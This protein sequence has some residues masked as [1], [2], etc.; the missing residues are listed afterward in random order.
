MEFDAELKAF[1]SNEQAGY[2]NPA[3][4]TL[5]PEFPSRLNQLYVESV[6]SYKNSLNKIKTTN[7]IPSFNYF[8]K[9]YDQN[10]DKNANDLKGNGIKNVTKNVII[11]LKAK[12][13]SN[14]S[15]NQANAN[16]I[17]IHPVSS[18]Y[19]YTRD[20]FNSEPNLISNRNKSTTTSNSSTK[21]SQKSST[22]SILPRGLFKQFSFCTKPH[23]KPEKKPPHKFPSRSLDNIMKNEKKSYKKRSRSTSKT[24]DLSEMRP[25]ESRT[26]ARKSIILNSLN[27]LANSTEALSLLDQKSG[28]C[29]SVSANSLNSARNDLPKSNSCSSLVILKENFK[30]K[31]VLD[32]RM[33]QDHNEIWNLAKKETKANTN[34]AKSAFKTFNIKKAISNLY[35]SRSRA[36]SNGKDAKNKKKTA[37]ASH[38]SRSD[39]HTPKHSI[40]SK[41]SLINMYFFKKS[42]QSSTKSNSLANMAFFSTSRRSTSSTSARF[43]SNSIDLRSYGEK[44]G[45]L[46]DIVLNLFI[47]SEKC[48]H[49][50]NAVCTKIDKLY[51]DRQLVNYM[52]YLLREDYIKNFLL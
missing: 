17:I 22:Y 46:N 11:D 29:S 15:S 5:Q 7:L 48:A 13:E 37:S 6:I 28:S 23:I 4:A 42:S 34:G 26:T 35:R 9:N 39:T 41:K 51:Y 2:L 43:N 30:N 3:G 25:I 36:A 32:Q 44:R 10:N 8:I 14:A 50:R 52:E 20:R 1:E 19:K 49:R 24:G 47:N 18:K 16:R 12:F 38:A 31:E 21:Q 45:E 27:I 33:I 40:T